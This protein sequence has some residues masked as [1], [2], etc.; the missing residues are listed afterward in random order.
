MAR[1][2]QFFCA[3][4]FFLSGAGALTYEILWQ[5]QMF[6]IF[7]ASA[8]ATTAILTAI[9]LGIAFGSQCAV[10][11]VKRFRPFW[12]YAVLEGVISGWGLLVPTML[13]IA[14]RLYV[15]TVSL[16]GEGHFLQS[17]L[18][19]AL[20]VVPLLPATLAMGATIPV[21]VKCAAGT[22]SAAAWAYGVNLLGAVAGALL[23]GFVWLEYLGISDTRFVAFSFNLIAALT[24][25]RLATRVQ[26]SVEVAELDP[27]EAPDGDRQGLGAMYFVAGFVALGL[28]VVWLRFLGIVNTN[29]TA[30]FTLALTVYLL[31]MGIGSLAL[32]PLL[33][34]YLSPRAVFSTANG[35][36]A[37][38][39]LLTFQVIYVAASV[40]YERIVRPSLAGVLTP[41][42]VFL[43]EAW[44][45]ALL[46]FVPTLFMGLAYPAVCDCY[47]RAGSSR[48]RWVGRAYFLG[49]LGSVLGVLLVAMWIIPRLGLHGAFSLLVSLSAG[50]CVVSTLS[51]RSVRPGGVLVA[52]LAMVAVAG[53]ISY[54]SRPVLRETAAIKKD[55]RWMEA[56]IPGA[57]D[58]IS[59]LTSV[60]AGATATV[61]IKKPVGRREHLVYVDDQLVAST[62]LE[63]KVDSLMLAHLPLL[64]HHAPTSALTVGFGTGGTSAAMI[65]HGVD[66]YCVEIEPEVPRAAYLMPQQNFNVLD[67]PQ[68]TLILN[69]ARDH[70][71]AGLRS[72]DVIATDVTN[73]QYK[74][75]GNLYTVEYFDL[76]RKKL[77][78]GGIACVLDSNGSHR[79]PGAANPDARIRT[80]HFP[81]RH[82]GT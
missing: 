40:N 38:A 34:R 7:G 14:D 68:F 66:T 11:A 20:A 1:S 35:G 55:G 71:H 57:G 74:Q 10:P 62:N 61:M 42:D 17:P 25:M 52:C 51:Q 5:R 26:R 32:Y 49:T 60:R 80:A 2:A 43:T 48:D 4:A 53:W 69:D 44:I 64:L 12:L 82:F 19:F 58:F 22:S 9:F 65:A 72:Y 73:L 75:N 39:A 36:T 27:I 13:G 3:F 70:L 8:P 41:S 56:A 30:T 76:M 31:G 79:P 16:I 33:I 59:E 6:L 77:N 24:A 15:M 29:S 47:P 54:E 28:E 67:E 45:V 18:R 21:M 23:T 50:L 46:I 63:A 37:L 78:P 81:M